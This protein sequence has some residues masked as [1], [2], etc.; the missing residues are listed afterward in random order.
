[1]DK[2]RRPLQQVCA[3]LDLDK[4]Q[5][6]GAASCLASNGQ[7][8]PACACF[9]NRRPSH[10]GTPHKRVAGLPGSHGH[11]DLVPL[12]PRLCWP[13]PSEH[14]RS[15]QSGRNPDQNKVDLSGRA[16]SSVV[17][18]RTLAE[19]KPRRRKSS[20]GTRDGGEE[21]GE[22]RQVAGLEAVPWRCSV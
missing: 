7:A 6:S 22:A 18:G 10:M 19:G 1:M 16:R 11:V 2:R 8:A 12:P 14:S 13:A 15:I 4:L 17:R 5:S 21:T 20:E 3:L 9:R